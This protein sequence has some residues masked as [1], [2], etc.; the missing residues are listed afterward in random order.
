M[1]RVHN[2]QAFDHLW[3]AHS[4]DPCQHSTPIM[5][6][7]DRLLLAQTPYQPF[8]IMQKGRYIIALGRFVRVIVATQIRSNDSIAVLSE[9]RY[10]M[11]P[12]IPELGEAMQANDQG[13]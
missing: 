10:L 4:K 12:R 6:Y 13:N 1:R 5:S 9:E 7:D 11:P 2:D 3:I 8:D